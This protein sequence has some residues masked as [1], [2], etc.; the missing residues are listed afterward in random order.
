VVNPAVE[1]SVRKLIAEGNDKTALEQAKQI[2]KACG[3]A[4]SEALLVD[5]YAGRIRSLLRRNL[6]LE[7]QSLVELVR[8]RYPSSRTRLSDLISSVSARSGRLDD[9]V[10]P[11]NDPALD[12]AQRAAIERALQHEIS[13]LAAL[14]R[15]EA[16][17]VEHPLR[18]AAAAL[19]RALI[20]ATSGPMTEDALAIPEVSHR[21]PLAPWKLLVRAVASFYRGE[22]ESCRRCLDAIDPE[23][24]PAR[25]VPALRAM[26]EGGGV[27]PLSP[28]AESLRARVT[29]ESSLRSALDALDQAFAAGGRGRILKAIRPVVEECQ[30]SAPDQLDS[31]RQHISVRCAVAD[32]DPA[33]VAAAMGGPSRHDATFLRLFA[34]ALEETHDAE[35]IVI[36]C[37]VW[38][39]FREVAARE[40]W[41]PPNGAESAALALHAADLLR[42]LP[43]GLLRELRYSLRSKAEN[44]GER[45]SFALPEELYQRAC[46]L[47]PHPEA[48]AQWMEW[49][50]QSGGSEQVAATWHRLRPQD[51]EPLLHLMKT[52]EARGAF[53]SALSHV[54]K[55]ERIDSLHPEVRTARLRLMT[56]NALRHLHKKKHALASADVG[57]LAALPEMQQGDR[58]AFLAALRCIVST[59]SGKEE[60]ATASRAEVER[61]LES[62][63][64]A[65]VLLSAIAGAAK[66]RAL[67]P[68]GPIETLSA[69]ERTTLPVILARVAALAADVRVK[70]ELPGPWMLEVANQF[71]AGRPTL[72]TGQ[73][74]LL[75]EL[76]L[77]V[78]QFELAYA[79]SAEGLE[80]G[81]ATE[82][83]FL[84]LRARSVTGAVDRRVICAKAAA[85]LARHQQDTVLV[86]EAV[87]LV[88]DLVGVDAVSLNL[89][90]AREVLAK[91]RAATKPPRK[92]RRG[93]DYS[94]LFG[95]LCQ[96]EQC[97]RQRGEIA[98]LIDDFEPDAGED[99]GFDRPLEVP[100]E[101]AEMF[102]DEARKAMRR[103]ESVDE[104]LAKL[105][106]EG[107]P[108]G[109]R[110]KGRRK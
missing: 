36:A 87:E 77:R 48:F 65:A 67:W 46:A 31:L 2:H 76:A 11:L 28:A 29:R 89:E 86:E 98:G 43:E 53:Q 37:H 70:V 85:E 33:K 56:A 19:E 102:L 51:I 97:R 68:L 6:T 25:L 4:V 44:R 105:L 17:S 39:E 96:C 94:N 75:A 32:L 30:R 14:A 83:R 104:F 101:I 35:K 54:S 1:A 20:G 93:P 62:G 81:G 21:S 58:R 80:R 12:A 52:A 5:A 69:Q 103:G 40:G 72:N 71:P 61:L 107:P 26:L 16:L 73:L 47:D 99:F 60:D 24:A 90:Q 13:D 78:N 27:A 79:V 50:S 3:T 108:T 110:R 9:L 18:R 38:E 92:D 84:L 23:A 45:I 49:A 64:A 63:T 42:G 91:E 22:D 100:P 55:A 15:C 41:F 10:R 57:A 88:R 7:A 66:Q 34:R 59:L 109:R 8:Q 82:A 74:L 95:K 106:A